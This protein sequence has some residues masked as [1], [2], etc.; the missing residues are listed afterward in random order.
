MLVKVAVKS[1]LH[2]GSVIIFKLPPT[3]IAFALN[4][5]A[6]HVLL[7]GVAVRLPCMYIIHAVARGQS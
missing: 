3:M 5:S 7:V 2:A 4:L 6:T 1:Y